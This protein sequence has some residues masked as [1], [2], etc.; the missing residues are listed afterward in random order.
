MVGVVLATAAVVLVGVRLSGEAV[1]PQRSAPS[2]LTAPAAP[3][4]PTDPTS[5]TD[6]VSPAS[7]GASPGRIA[8]GTV[9]AAERPED[10]VP[11][12]LAATSLPQ[13][14]DGA[15]QGFVAGAHFALASEAVRTDPRAALQAFSDVL[16]PRDRATLG[17]IDRRGGVEFT[18]A[19]GAYRVLGH[20]GEREQPDKV[21]VEV[22]APLR[23]AGKARWAIV[24]G[25]VAYVDGRWQIES[26]RPSTPA[27]PA[28]GTARVDDMTAR[29]QAR[30]LTGL[31]WSTF[32]RTRG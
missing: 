23:A 12:L 14:I 2:A 24:G 4:A 21:M 30:M 16:D 22:A 26:I 3:A 11:D 10:A 32:A 17:G 13:T 19:A 29:E 20:A 7:P 15:V 8:P 28:A 9:A 6:P 25:V 18:P 1:S 31:G 5:P 27:Q